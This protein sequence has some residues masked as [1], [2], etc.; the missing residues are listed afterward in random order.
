MQLMSD[1]ID[2]ILDYNHEYVYFTK[3]KQKQKQKGGL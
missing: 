2:V 1:I 3:T